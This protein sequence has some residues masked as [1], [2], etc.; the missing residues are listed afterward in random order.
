MGDLGSTRR[1]GRSPGEG[2]GS[3]V[4]YSG[5]ENSHGQ[6][7]L[8]GYSPWGCK[9]SDTAERLSAAEHCK[10]IPGLSLCVFATAVC[11][12]RQWAELTYIL[13][14]FR[15]GQL[16]LTCSEGVRFPE[17]VISVLMGFD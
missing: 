16:A 7:S 2:N 6:R 5:L 14:V 9:E 3:R 4:H 17:R 12:C 8:S 1:L 15:V 13:A 10:I 11:S